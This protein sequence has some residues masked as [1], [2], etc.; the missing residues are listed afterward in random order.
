MAFKTYP[1]PLANHPLLGTIVEVRC[2]IYENHEPT[3]RD[4]PSDPTD[5][6]GDYELVYADGRV[7]RVGGTGYEVEGTCVRFG[8]FRDD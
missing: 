8:P 1:Y 3:E 2:L 7:V 5:V 6:Q 4:A